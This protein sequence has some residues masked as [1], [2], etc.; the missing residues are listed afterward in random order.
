MTC[1]G[2]LRELASRKLAGKWLCGLV[3]LAKWF[4]YGFC[5]MSGVEGGQ[6]VTLRSGE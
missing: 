6:V 4:L 3:Q 1:F 5:S 2:L